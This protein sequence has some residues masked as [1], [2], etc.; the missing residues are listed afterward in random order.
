VPSEKFSPKAAWGVNLTADQ[1]VF[2]VF[3]GY[4][5]G[6]VP[7]LPWSEAPLMPE[8]MM[9]SDRLININSKGFLTINSQ[10]RVNGESS[11]NER[12]GWGPKGGLVYQKAYLEFFTSADNLK[13]LI[14]VL[15]QFP[16]V[17]YHAINL[18]GDDITN[19]TSHVCAITWGVFPNK[20]IIQPT[21]VDP[22]SF[23]VW[24]DEAFGLWHSLWATLYD[25]GSHS[26]GV[27]QNMINTYYL[28][29]VVDNNFIDGD[30]FAIFDAVEA[31]KLARST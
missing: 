28:V 29:N 27:I 30:I 22:T 20:E 15:K 3:A 7:V 6:Q 18:K 12:L 5:S 8:S 19:T 16:S 21:V 17:Q 31:R 2:N 13:L 14:D 25:E 26:R 1:D 24:K 23:V 11:S 9:I 4:C 10:P